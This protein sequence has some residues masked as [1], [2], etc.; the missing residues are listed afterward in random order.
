ML[1]DGPGRFIAEP[2]VV[3]RDARAHFRQLLRVIGVDE[4]Q[5]FDDSLVEVCEQ[6]A[7]AG[8]DAEARQ[9]MEQWMRRVPDDPGGLLRR[10]FRYQYQRY[11]R[12]QEGR[13][14]WPDDEV[15]PW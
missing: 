5:F 7:D 1:E 9:A 4:G 14:I 12:D 15:Q 13:E 8:S 2:Y 11:G 6:L 3:E 10:K